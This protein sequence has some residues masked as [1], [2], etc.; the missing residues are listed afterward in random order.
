MWAEPAH[1]QSVPK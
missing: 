1:M